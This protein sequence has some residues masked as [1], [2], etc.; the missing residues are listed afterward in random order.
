MKNTKAGK[1]MG[2]GKLPIQVFEFFLCFNI[3]N[4]KEYLHKK[5]L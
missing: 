5:R 2:P 4:Q 1:I 3:Q